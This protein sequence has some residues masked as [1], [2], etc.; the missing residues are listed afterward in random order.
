M[1]PIY[2]K[3]GSC[4]PREWIIPKKLILP[5]ERILPGE[6]IECSKLLP[7]TAQLWSSI[8]NKSTNIRSNKW[9][10]KLNHQKN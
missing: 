4:I 1:D 8:I 6:W 5:K 10:T 9:N 2:I 7:S 3:N